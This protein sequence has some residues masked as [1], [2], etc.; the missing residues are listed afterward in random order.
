MFKIGE[1]VGFLHESG[2]AKIVEFLTYGFVRI[3][4]NDGFEQKRAVSELIKLHGTEHTL[5]TSIP[6]ES[7]SVSKKKP[8]IQHQQSLT[9]EIDLH[10]E[11]LLNSHAQLSTTDILRIQ[12][13]HFKLKFAQAKQ[14]KV[15]KLIII[16]G[17]GKGVLKNEIR[18]FL[19]KEEGI[20]FYDA[21]FL[22]YGQGATEIKFYISK[23]K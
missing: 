22:E 3:I 18:S 2:D 7:L 11:N 8:S 15:S 17:V 16:H 6:K 5:D 9:W 21:S 12:L 4:D 23:I 20:E 1:K 19:F 14:Q 13:Q 10:I